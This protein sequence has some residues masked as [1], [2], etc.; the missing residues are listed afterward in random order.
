MS[1]LFWVAYFLAL[2]CAMNNSVWLC[3]AKLDSNSEASF[4]SFH[5]DFAQEIPITGLRDWLV[6][7]LRHTPPGPRVCP[8]KACGVNLMEPFLTFP[9][10][11]VLKYRTFVFTTVFV[12]LVVA[13]IYQQ[14]RKPDVRR[15]N[16]WN[17]IFPNLV[18]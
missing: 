15:G 9:H 11:D 10:R 6:E 1:V 13:R 14:N 2:A 17:D 12:D 16:S 18:H 3:A 8:S 5:F 7:R 4:S